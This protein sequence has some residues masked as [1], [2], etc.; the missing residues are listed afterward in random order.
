M[1]RIHRRN[2][3]NSAQNISVLLSMV[4]NGV[5]TMLAKFY[6]LNRSKI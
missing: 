3:E 4:S 2:K 5:L 6:S 1:I